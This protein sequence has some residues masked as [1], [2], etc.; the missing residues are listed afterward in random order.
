MQILLL[1]SIAPKLVSFERSLRFA[2][3]RNIYRTVSTIVPIGKIV[4]IERY[5]FERVRRR[6]RN[7]IRRRT[8]DRNK[9]ERNLWTSTV[10]TPSP[11]LS[12]ASIVEIWI[13]FWTR[14]EPCRRCRIKQLVAAEEANEI[15][16]TGLFLLRLVVFAETPPNRATSLVVVEWCRF[17]LSPSTTTDSSRQS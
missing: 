4:S 10:A 5:R 14:Y 7:D 8:Y 12:S 13:L 16:K 1:T 11:I 9:V 15:W 3:I 6:S 17:F 2:H